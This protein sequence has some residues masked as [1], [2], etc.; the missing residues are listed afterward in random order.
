MRRF[1]VGLWAFGCGGCNL[2]WDTDGL[3]YDEDLVGVDGSG[4]V[5][6]PPSVVGVES[7]PGN[8]DGANGGLG[9]PWVAAGPGAELPDPLHMPLSVG[10][11]FTCA[12]DGGEVVCAGW[13]VWGQMGNGTKEDTPTPGSVQGI[14]NAV[15][16]DTGEHFACALLETGAVKCWGL[17]HNGRLGGG[18]YVGYATIPQVVKI[19]NVTQLAVGRRHAC[20][21]HS[22]ESVWCWGKD[23]KS[24]SGA[25]LW[26]DAATPV[27]V[28]GLSGGA[29]DVAAGE[30]HNCA[31]LTD[32]T[33]ACWGENDHG[34]LGDGSTSDSAVPVAV[35]GVAGAVRVESWSDHSCALSDQAEVYCWGRNDDGQI[36]NGERKSSQTSAAQP[37]GDHVWTDLSVGDRQTCAVHDLDAV[38]CWG[39]GSWGELGAG[40]T[41]RQKQPA[42]VRADDNGSV[43]TGVARVATGLQSSCALLDSGEVWCWGRNREGQLGL[44]DLHQRQLFAVMSQY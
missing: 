5:Q 23:Q 41:Q 11:H 26:N 7:T 42:Q 34:Q 21:V 36:G 10:E 40:D 28:Q 44:G 8:G 4:A 3:Q 20:I 12:L 31:V 29:L 6:V 1:W 9:G 14:G 37:I 24:Q 32:G 18:E 27:Q 33:V 43:L 17:R 39:S 30:E 15:S 35:V 16:V 13:G 22:D 25:L 19:A 38:Y 2:I